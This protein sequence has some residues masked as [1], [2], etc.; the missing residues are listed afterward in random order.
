[1]RQQTFERQAVQRQG[2]IL[3]LSAFMLAMLGAI[4][5]LSVNT[6]YIALAKTEMRLACDA[7]VKAASIYYGLTG[8]ANA[9]GL[10]ARQICQRHYVAGLPLQIR[11]TDVQFG[12][13]SSNGQGRYSF[14]ANA[15]PI[16]STQ[17]Y[18]SFALRSGSAAPLTALG[19]FLGKESFALEEYSVA[20]RVDNDI[21]LV[22]DRSGS[23]A[24]DLTNDSYSYPGEMHGRSIIQNYFLP[25]H[26]T[27]SRW[28]ALGTAIDSFLGVLE[29]NP[30]HPRVALV[31]YASNF[32]FGEFT[33]TVSSIDQP[34]TH[35]FSQITARIDVI[36]S[37]PIIG[38]TN[39]AAGLRDGLS[40]LAGQSTSRP[41]A[42]HNIVLLTD[43]MLTQGD[44][45]VALAATALSQNIKVH[46]ITFSAQ[47]DQDLMQQVA[48]AGGGFH[49]HA[50]D[51]ATLSSIFATL[52]ETLPAMLVE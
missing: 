47:A 42:T 7:S 39:I 31:S 17:V 3:V 48:T 14:V 15:Q 16:N 21:C 4:A 6:A 38:N 5:A 1:M 27:G 20:T 32:E 35:D 25:P 12:H 19:Q 43:G 44:D 37:R 8:D 45:P 36:G 34:L 41:H 2:T 22:V 52:A 9:A 26:P 49:Y 11:G 18:A 28:A 29:S 50:P 23:M 10:Q 13:A 33:S 40:A 51:A 46:T 30:Y 24:W